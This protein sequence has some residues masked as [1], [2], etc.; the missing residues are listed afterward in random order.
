MHATTATFLAGG[1]G[2]AALL[3]L[4][5]YSWLFLSRSSVWLISLPFRVPGNVDRVIPVRRPATRGA[6]LRQVVGERHLGRRAALRVVPVEVG[7]AVAALVRLG[8]AHRQEG[9]TFAAPVRE[10]AAHAGRD[11]GGVAVAERVNLL[12]LDLEG[13]RALE[14]DVGLLLALVAVDAAALTRLEHQQV[15][16]EALDPQLVADA[17]EP[18]AGLEVELG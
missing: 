9:D 4:A 10:P 8:A 12:A 3:K 16:P 17:D 18:L 11:A 5:A 15:E 14:D 1:V 13:E 6:R 7:D 2:R